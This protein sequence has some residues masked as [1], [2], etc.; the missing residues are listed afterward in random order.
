MKFDLI[1]YQSKKT[2]LCEKKLSKLL[3]K[4]SISVNTT[5]FATTPIALGQRLVESLNCCYLVFVIGNLSTGDSNSFTRVISRAI[6]NSKLTLGNTKKLRS[7]LGPDGY[8]ISCGKQVIVA[9]PDDP[10]EIE[11]MLS[12]EVIDYITKTVP[13]E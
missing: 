6:A 10:C 8:I 12:H 1:F 7:L 13:T 3:N 4:S 11:A 9:L 5:A 2:S